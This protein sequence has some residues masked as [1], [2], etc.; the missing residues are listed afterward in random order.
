MATTYLDPPDFKKAQD[1]IGKALTLDSQQ[2]YYHQTLGWIYEQKERQAKNEDFLERALQEYQTAL[3]LNDNLQ[4]SD[5]EANLLLNLGNGHFALKN[6]YPAYQYFRKRAL[7]SL[8]FFDSK[9][10]AIFRQRYG[11]MA[12]KMGFHE[13]AVSP[14]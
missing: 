11:E 2:V 3:A 10:E 12:F 9:R 8:K 7:H 4:N 14:A 1:E 13:E 5:N 6:Y